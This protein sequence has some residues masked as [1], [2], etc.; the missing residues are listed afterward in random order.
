MAPATA[1]L[2]S[3]FEATVD[4]GNGLVCFTNCL[5][6][7]ED[8][9]MIEKDL[10]ID[11][12]RGAILDAHVSEKMLLSCLWNLKIDHIV[13]RTFFLRKERPDT[14]IDLGGNVLRLADRWR[15]IKPPVLTTS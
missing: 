7:Q 15:K 3:D 9:S 2:E 4:D 12:R 13:K 11:G 6:P 8:G 14:V 5:L 10:W 1:T